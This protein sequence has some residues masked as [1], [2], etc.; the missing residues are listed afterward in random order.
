MFMKI[1]KNVV[2]KVLTHRLFFNII[3]IFLI[4]I[5]LFNI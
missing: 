4:T 5:Y 1:R 3:N 2:F